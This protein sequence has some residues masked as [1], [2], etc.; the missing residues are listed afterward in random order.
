[1]SIEHRKALN[2]ATR[3]SRQ[4]FKAYVNIRE[5]YREGKATPQELAHALAESNRADTKLDQL[6]NI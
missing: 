1:M 5:A 4:A 6:S 3:K 2:Q